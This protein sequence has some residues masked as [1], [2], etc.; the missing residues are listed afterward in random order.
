[1]KWLYLGLGMS[2]AIVPTIWIYVAHLPY[3]F[4]ALPIDLGLLF[5]SL[6]L[7]LLFSPIGVVAGLIVAAIIHFGWNLKSRRSG[8][9]A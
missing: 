4:S 5:F 6:G 2:G 9:P 7:G 8:N 1:M 3:A